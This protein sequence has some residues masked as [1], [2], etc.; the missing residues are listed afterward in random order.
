VYLNQVYRPESKKCLSSWP[1]LKSDMRK[2][3]T[4]DLGCAEIA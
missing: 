4:L 3:F 1:R 2:R